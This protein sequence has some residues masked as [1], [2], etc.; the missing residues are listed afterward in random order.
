MDE[1]KKK[2]EEEKKK[3]GENGGDGGDE[4]GGNRRML[5]EK[6]DSNPRRLAEPDGNDGNS[7]MPQIGGSG[8][9]PTT[10]SSKTGS[11]GESGGEDKKSGGDEKSESPVKRPDDVDPC[12]WAMVSYYASMKKEPPKDEAINGVFYRKS[13]EIMFTESGSGGLGKGR[14]LA[15]RGLATSDS[16]DVP[17]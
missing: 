4:K 10:S 15:T 1:E 17:K 12:V 8:S 3:E 6:G 11:P 5:F 2:E 16:K 13:G 14:I 9:G 7:G